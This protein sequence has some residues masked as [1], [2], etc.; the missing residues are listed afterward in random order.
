MAAARG[1]AESSSQGWRL[2]RLGPGG[3]GQGG[4]QRGAHHSR[5]ARRPHSRAGCARDR[6]RKPRAVAMAARRVGL[7]VGGVMGS[8]CCLSPRGH[9]APCVPEGA[10]QLARRSGRGHL[11][12]PT[13]S[14]GAVLVSAPVAH[15]APGRPP[16]TVP[17][18]G[19]HLLAPVPSGYCLGPVPRVLSHYSGL[20]GT[21]AGRLRTWCCCEHLARVRCQPPGP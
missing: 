13:P 9:S 8:Q 12:P 4:G 16:P 2:G 5:A 11:S 17:K 3:Q 20:P 14:P 18:E 7:R 1:P 19:G 15:P 10:A 21:G 6:Q